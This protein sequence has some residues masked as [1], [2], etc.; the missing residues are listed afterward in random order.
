[1]WRAHAQ[2]AVSA[3]DP[4]EP[5]LEVDVLV[6]VAQQALGDC[7]SLSAPLEAHHRLER[8][9]AQLARVRERIRLERDKLHH[10]EAAIDEAV[11]DQLYA[12]M[13]LSTA[14]AY[15]HGRTVRFVQCSDSALPHATV[16]RVAL[17]Q[18]AAIEA[19]CV[20][21]QSSPRDQA[22]LEQYLDRLLDVQLQPGLPLRRMWLWTDSGSGEQLVTQWVYRRLGQPTA[23]VLPG[24]TGLRWSGAWKGASVFDI[25]LVTRP[26]RVDQSL[27]PALQEARIDGAATS[28]LRDVH[29]VLQ[30]DVGT[31]DDAGRRLADAGAWWC[32]SMRA[33]AAATAVAS[34]STG[35]EAIKRPSTVDAAPGVTVFDKKQSPPAG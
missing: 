22:F 21:R 16:H 30:T 8:C 29:V 20:L 3:A 35:Q 19:D 27:L 13:C 14:D 33:A 7:P 23:E 6:P 18:A 2:W 24:D 17:P 34:V 12:T 28:H 1:M 15:R 10:C 25:T 11:R 5:H 32:F 9:T 31:D 4:V 26:S